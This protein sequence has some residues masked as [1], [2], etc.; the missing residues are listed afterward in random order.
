MSVRLRLSSY[1]SFQLCL[2]RERS[3]DSRRSDEEHGLKYLRGFPV[4][5]DTSVKTIEIVGRRLNNG[6]GADGSVYSISVF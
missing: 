2:S 6:V 5:W 1:F 3:L 4:I